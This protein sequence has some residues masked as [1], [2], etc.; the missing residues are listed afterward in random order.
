M[1]IKILNIGFLAMLLTSCGI[2]NHVK[3]LA[4]ETV[5]SVSVTEGDYETIYQVLHENFTD[6]PIDS[7]RKISYEKNNDNY[8]LLINLNRNKFKMIYR[9]NVGLN[10]TVEAVK[11]KIEA[12]KTTGS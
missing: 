2:K 8:S 4:Y 9:S 10:E 5:Y 6:F 1:K 7:T 12:I 3:P 11:S